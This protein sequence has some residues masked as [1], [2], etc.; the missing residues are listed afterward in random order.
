MALD[1]EWA[2]MAEGLEGYVHS[3]FFISVVVAVAVGSCNGWLIQFLIQLL[4]L[5]V[6]HL[7][8]WCCGSMDTDFPEMQIVLLMLLIILV[9]FSRTIIAHN[10]TTYTF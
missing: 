2:V 8:P 10:E 1:I 6:L 4:T 7:S 3:I 9:N 5:D